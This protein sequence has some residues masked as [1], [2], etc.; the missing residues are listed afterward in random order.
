MKGKTLV[1]LACIILIQITAVAG[2]E[3]SKQSCPICYNPRINIPA[4]CT[5]DEAD[6]ERTEECENDEIC[7]IYQYG[8]DTTGAPSRAQV[9]EEEN[10]MYF[11]GTLQQMG[12]IIGRFGTGDV[13]DIDEEAVT[14]TGS[15]STVSPTFLVV[16]DEVT[17]EVTDA[18][19]EATESATEEDTCE[20]GFRITGEV[21]EKCPLDTYSEAESSNECTPCLDGKITARTGS[22][23]AA[24]CIEGCGAGSYLMG[25]SCKS[26][27]LNKYSDEQ[28]NIECKDCPEGKVTAG[29]ESTS[30]DECLACGPGTYLH[31]N[32]KACEACQEGKYSDNA[33]HNPK[34]TAC[35]AGMTSEDGSSSLNDCKIITCA[36]GN[37][38]DADYICGMCEE[39]TYIAE[40][41]HSLSECTPCPDGTTSET[42]SSS[43]DECKG[44]ATEAPEVTPTEDSGSKV[45]EI[46]FFLLMSIMVLR[47]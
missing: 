35:P 17:D 41:V 45:L 12:S 7:V 40:E 18:D 3:Y 23:S 44:E 43:E 14:A 25:K 47:F 29:T 5:R 32:T 30:A 2:Y 34:C 10:A 6:Y 15:T 42:G 1:V 16:T 13:R 20:A 27:P 33:G 24:D 37:K 46:S 9:H 4:E 26:C 28:H 8:N 19:T 38:L 36:A 39:N 11:C 21:C 31:R 22:S